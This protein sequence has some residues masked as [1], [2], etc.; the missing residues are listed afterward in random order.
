MVVSSFVYF[1]AQLW[2]PLQT[3]SV[4]W[5]SNTTMWTQAAYG[6]SD[7]TSEKVLLYFR[8]LLDCVSE[9]ILIVINGKYTNFF[10]HIYKIQ[11]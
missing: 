1:Q 5:S 8:D 6:T 4:T 3:P 11:I 9:E 2:S 10:L 7:A